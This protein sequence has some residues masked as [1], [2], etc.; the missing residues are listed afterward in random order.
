MKTF[1][2]LRPCVRLGCPPL[3]RFSATLFVA[4]GAAFVPDVSRGQG[5]GVEL[6]QARAAYVASLETGQPEGGRMTLQPAPDRKLLVLSVRVGSALVRLADFELRE[7]GRGVCVPW[8]AAKPENGNL[9]HFEI[10]RHATAIGPTVVSLAWSAPAYYRGPLRLSYGDSQA[11]VLVARYSSWLAE[12]VAGP[13]PQ[14]RAWAAERLAADPNISPRELKSVLQP[15]LEK[16]GDLGARK[17]IEA[18]LA[19]L[20]S[21]PESPAGAVARE[22]T[23]NTGKYRIRARLLEVTADAVRLKKEDGETVEVP[24]NRLSPADREFAT[25][26]RQ[27]EISP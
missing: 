27:P 21:A 1:G 7:Q 24:L 15:A 9:L 20:D 8:G 14:I 5:S 16:E 10:D 22:W 17:R 18:A 12:L 26:Q 6:S 23:D 13:S 19:S 11:E 25:R 4:I 2:P 3:A